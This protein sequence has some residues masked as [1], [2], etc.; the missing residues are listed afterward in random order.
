MY[1][2]T[3]S[4][5]SYADVQGGIRFSLSVGAAGGCKLPDMM[6]GIEPGSSR[7]IASTFNCWAIYSAPK[8]GFL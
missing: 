5:Y 1:V 7:K 8:S 3:G 2:C 4:M 6:L